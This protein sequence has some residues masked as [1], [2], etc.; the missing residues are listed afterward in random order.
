MTSQLRDWDSRFGLPEGSV[1]FIDALGQ[2]PLE[3]WLFVLRVDPCVALSV[4]SYVDTVNE[5]YTIATPA[6]AVT[7]VASFVRLT[8]NELGWLDT[9]HGENVLRYTIASQEWGRGRWSSC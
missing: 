2:D 5:L 1:N 9:S 8:L 7:A 3:Y 6:S 4:D